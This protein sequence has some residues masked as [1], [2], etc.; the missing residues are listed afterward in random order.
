MGAEGLFG[1][2]VHEPLRR[3]EGQESPVMYGYCNFQLE[4][5]MYY[6]MGQLQE[7]GVAAERDQ[8]NYK[9]GKGKRTRDDSNGFHETPEQMSY[10][11]R[12]Q[13]G[14]LQTSYRDHLSFVPNGKLRC[15]PPPPPAPPPPV[16]Q[17]PALAQT[18]PPPSTL[19]PLAFKSARK[20][21]YR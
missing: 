4:A 20:K 14:D 10:S 16:L 19:T 21:A 9:T 2:T 5:E 13:G 8:W 6:A 3:G 12:G 17:T 15:F 11:G 18:S 7:R 1:V